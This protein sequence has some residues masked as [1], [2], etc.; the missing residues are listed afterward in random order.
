MYRIVE[1]TKDNITVYIVYN[2]VKGKELA[3]YNTY[4]EAFLHVLGL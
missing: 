3:R 4:H 2:Q 1:F